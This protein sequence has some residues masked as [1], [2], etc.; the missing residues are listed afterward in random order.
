MVRK[1]FTMKSIGSFLI[2]PSL[3][4]FGL[5]VLM[6]MGNSKIDLSPYGKLT[7]SNEP[8]QAT[9]PRNNGAASLWRA[10]I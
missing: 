8:D 7:L 10:P 4:T 2:I 3:I 6:T 5:E 9:G 1:D